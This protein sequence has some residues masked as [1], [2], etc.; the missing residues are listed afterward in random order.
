M[1]KGSCECGAVTY[2]TRGP[3]RNVVACHC[4]QCRKTSGHHW[5]ATKVKTEALH[6]TSEAGLKW[7]RSSDRAQRG[8]CKDCGSSLF[9]RLDG[10]DATAIGIG[11]LDGATGLTMTKHI[12][13]ADKG[14]YY[15]IT[16]GLP[17]LDRN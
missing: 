17:Q 15:D 4:G 7:Y 2:E 5:A 14:D 9:W 10:E 3:L 6:F 11:T 16:D 12:F 1:H 13:V 8:F